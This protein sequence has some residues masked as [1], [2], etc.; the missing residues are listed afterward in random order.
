MAMLNAIDANTMRP[1][2]NVNQLAKRANEF[3]LKRPIN[4]GLQSL[5]L[6]YAETQ[7]RKFA[8]WETVWR[9]RVEEM[10]AEG[11]SWFAIRNAL[12]TDSYTIRRF[13][14]HYG[15]A[16]ETRKHPASYTAPA[17]PL[18]PKI[19]YQS[20]ESWLAAGNT[21][22]RCPTAAAERT[23]A[24]IPEADMAALRELY[25]RREEERP[26]GRNGAAMKAKTRQRGKNEG[27]LNA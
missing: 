19:I 17:K 10:R 18:P 25:A 22:T 5:Q 1:I 24:T 8:K 23:T 6:A 21:V 9:P 20:V 26:K 12:N 13:R 3:K 14:A 11:R 7:R 15:Y 2:T 27:W 16:D 4:P